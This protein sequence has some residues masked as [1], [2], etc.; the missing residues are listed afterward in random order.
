MRRVLIVSFQPPAAK[1]TRVSHVSTVSCSSRSLATLN[2]PGKVNMCVF[3]IKRP[4]AMHAR[5]W[6]LSSSVSKE[7]IVSTGEAIP[8]VG[9]VTLFEVPVK[10]ELDF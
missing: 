9:T 10:G 8:E 6:A 4:S 2:A 1:A 3:A 5:P 7:R